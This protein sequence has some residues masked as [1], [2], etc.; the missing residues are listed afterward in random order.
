M[1]DENLEEPKAIKSPEQ[2]AIMG[3]SA[4]TST[5]NRME[6][7]NNNKNSVPNFDRGNPNNLLLN[8]NLI[9]FNEILS[10]RYEADNIIS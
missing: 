3:T 10:L 8:P 1:I 2:W 7:I 4:S 5:H 9:N 6:N